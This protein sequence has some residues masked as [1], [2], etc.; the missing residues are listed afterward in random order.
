MIK[1]IISDNYLL[2]VYTDYNYSNNLISRICLKKVKILIKLY[3]RSFSICAIT[4]TQ[5]KSKH[6]FPYV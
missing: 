1:K 4:L 2:N 5:N 6:Q 3:R